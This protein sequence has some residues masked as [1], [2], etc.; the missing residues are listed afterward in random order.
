MR[1]RAACTRSRPGKR[2]LAAS[3]RQ[4]ENP[5]VPS[6]GLP[7]RI[8]PALLEPV[9]PWW[10]YRCEGGGCQTASIARKSAHRFFVASDATKRTAAHLRFRFVVAAS[11]SKGTSFAG[12]APDLMRHRQDL[13][14]NGQLVWASPSRGNCARRDAV[15]RV[16]GICTG[17]AAVTLADRHSRHRFQP[18]GQTGR[19]SRHAD[20]RPL[21]ASGNAQRAGTSDNADR[22][23]RCGKSVRGV[24]TASPACTGTACANRKG[25]AFAIR[26]RC[27]GSR[28]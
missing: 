2:R 20:R 12:V 13:I 26:A 1:K 19:K 3:M 16:V 8:G 14:D 5:L 28:Q 10:R 6:C 17:R 11:R 23:C 24:R 27:A 4:M 21:S 25:R 9:D 7:P 18:A 22:F 15:L